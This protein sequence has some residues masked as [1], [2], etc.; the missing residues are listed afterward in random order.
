MIK[1]NKFPLAMAL[2]G[3]ALLM[4]SLGKTPENVIPE[5]T[6]EHQ[7][8]IF[9]TAETDKKK[10][11]GPEIVLGKPSENLTVQDIDMSV[12]PQW[13]AT[14]SES[15]D[16]LDPNPQRTLERLKK[17][18]NRMTELQRQFLVATVVQGEASDNERS[19]AIFMLTLDPGTAPASFST[20]AAMEVQIDENADPHSPE[21]HQAFF[22]KSLASR[23]AMELKRRA[24]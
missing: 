9:K 5:M 1:K 22:T 4:I 19:L 14:E 12:S 2:T 23:A 15:M 24:Q 7:T 6:E 3:L 18:A 20:I 8:V 16:R 11:M 13:L 21:L 10:P 17:I